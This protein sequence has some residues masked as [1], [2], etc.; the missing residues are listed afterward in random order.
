MKE[1]M[2]TEKLKEKIENISSYSNLITIYVICGS[3][4]VY[5]E[6]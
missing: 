1:R 3:L 6:S 5:S 4:D 2:K